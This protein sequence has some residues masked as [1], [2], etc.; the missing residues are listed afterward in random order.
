MRSHS[1]CFTVLYLCVLI[2]QCYI[3]SYQ[4]RDEKKNQDS[5]CQKDE[6]NSKQT[7]DANPPRAPPP[8]K[9]TML[10]SSSCQPN[11][12]SVLADLK[13]VTSNESNDQLE[14]TTYQ[15]ARVQNKPPSVQRTQPQS[16]DT[17]SN[18]VYTTKVAASSSDYPSE[19]LNN[20]SLKIK[21]PED[22][23]NTP[24]R[25]SP[26]ESKAQSI[27]TLT[28]RSSESETTPVPSTSEASA[29]PQKMS[30]SPSKTA[31]SRR[32]RLERVRS[33]SFSQSKMKS[34]SQS[35]PT[36]LNNMTK[37]PTSNPEKP[38]NKVTEEPTPKLEKPAPKPNVSPTT[39]QISARAAARDRYARHKKMMHQR[40][41]T[42]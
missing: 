39:S 21:Y 18:N 12:S 9:N 10:R 24:E 26:V 41:A 2:T 15:S 32:E 35:S 6:R 34:N 17:T 19:L 16:S 27:P 3:S 30:I 29:E 5:G 31:L 28:Q 22:E 11:M 14:K 25:T 8:K 40:K 23:P 7:I 36:V 38:A 13:R 1:V 42:N 20:A 37:E 33:R 4:K